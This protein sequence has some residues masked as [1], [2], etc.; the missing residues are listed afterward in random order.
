MFSAFLCYYL[1]IH[2]VLFK[3]IALITDNLLI[4][5]LLPS[6]IPQ[7]L[8]PTSLSPH[9]FLVL[10]KR[11][12]EK[13][14]ESLHASELPDHFEGESSTLVDVSGLDV[15]AE[16]FEY[17]VDFSIVNGGYLLMMIVQK[18]GELVALVFGPI[19]MLI[20]LNVFSGFG[21]TSG[22]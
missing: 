22:N 19:S 20:I 16:Y 11:F 12:L 17:F 21:G 4:F 8:Q 15:L 18:C 6:E 13:L 9:D 10:W 1:A 2:I 14:A 7:V 3:L 5:N